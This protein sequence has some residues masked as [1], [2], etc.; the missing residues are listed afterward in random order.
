MPEH[1]AQVTVL[2]VHSPWQSGATGDE[3]NMQ[4]NGNEAS[5]P[6]VFL[7]ETKHWQ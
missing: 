4:L 5:W 6:R 7:T 3:Y 1:D 2:R